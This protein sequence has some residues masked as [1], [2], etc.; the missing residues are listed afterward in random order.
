MES[1]LNSISDRL[2]K[3]I[4]NFRCTKHVITGDLGK[5]KRKQIF[6]EIQDSISEKISFC[7]LSTGSLIG[8]G[9]DLP[10]L[11][12]LVLA[13][14][15]SLRGRII[16]YAG[17]IHR[18]HRMKQV[19]IIHDYIDTSSGLT[20]SMFKKRVRAYKKMGYSIATGN[21]PEIAKCRT[22]VI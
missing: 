8:E 16:Q 4:C 18:E 6:A 10:E 12:T 9:F 19:V 21:S 1:L 11:D 2:E 7:I 13:M 5:N 20:I 15:I 17:R 3:V 22:R 14:P